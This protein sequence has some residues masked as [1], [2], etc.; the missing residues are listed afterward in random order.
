MKNNNDFF[1]PAE[2]LSCRL[3]ERALECTDL[4]RNA[5]EKNNKDKL[6]SNKFWSLFFD[7]Q[8]MFLHITDRLA[9]SILSI[10]NRSKFMDIL[11]YR[12]IESTI[13]TIFAT[14]TPETQDSYK[15]TMSNDYNISQA[16]YSRYENIYPKNV[17]SS[18][19]T[20]IGELGKKI[21]EKM[22][23]PLDIG[24]TLCLDW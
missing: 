2:K 21:S 10:Q 9:C 23:Y 1:V 3:F 7:F 13:D 18:K 20:V 8:F 16:L 15:K 17:K 4:I 6:E 5:Y 12:T 24:I 19:D 11:I 22:G 14:S